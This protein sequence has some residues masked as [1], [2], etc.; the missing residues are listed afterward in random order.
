MFLYMLNCLKTMKFGF[1]PKE[2]NDYFSEALDQIGVAEKYG[3]DSV[4]F[5]E[6]HENE[7][8]LPSPLSAL[9]SVFSYTNLKL[10]CIVILPLYHPYRLAEEIA[11]L[12]LISKGRVIIGVV[13]GYR[14]KDFKNF[15]FSLK[16]RSQLMDEGLILLDNLLRYESVNF[17]GK[18]F[19]L[20]KARVV[21]RPYQN[22]RPQIWV[23]AWKKK[24]IKRAALL[25][26]AWL[27]GQ[28]AKLVDVIKMKKVYEEEIKQLNKD[29]K[30]WPIIRDA[31]I[32]ENNDKAMSEA[33]SSIK[34]M[35]QLDY[36]PSGHPLIGGKVMDI[37]E[38]VEDRIL[39][40]DAEKAIEFI[41]KVKN[42]G[43]NYIIFRLSLRKL[44]NE[45]IKNSIRLLGERVIPY[46]SSEFKNA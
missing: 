18:I 14:E 32:A 9:Y 35:Y 21:P 10:G 46:F 3:F 34:E 37:M 31:Y 15:G 27:P 11:L 5:E 6:H 12:D 13:L 30:I 24:A 8:Y 19:K 40:G 2:W 23:G 22:P 41:N 42:A 16:E 29:V 33:E 17:D 4:W 43:F 1:I 39:V 38:W 7:L 26:D 36:S 44:K 45:Q 20:N 25:G 28:T